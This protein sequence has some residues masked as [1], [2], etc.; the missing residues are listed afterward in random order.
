M[1]Y[2]AI[3]LP[4]ASSYKLR[5]CPSLTAIHACHLL[6]LLLLSA[7]RP[8]MHFAKKHFL[9]TCLDFGVCVCVCCAAGLSAK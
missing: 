9:Q 4:A 3:T 8:Q 1:Y 2:S 6:L 5:L 7:L